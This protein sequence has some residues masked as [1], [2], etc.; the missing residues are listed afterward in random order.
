MNQWVK[1]Y[2]SV[3]DVRGVGL[4]IGIDIVS[5]KKIRHAIRSGFKDM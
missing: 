2:E 1:Q 4:S 3:G 5:D